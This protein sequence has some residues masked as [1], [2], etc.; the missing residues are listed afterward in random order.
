L[1]ASGMQDESM[2][3]EHYGTLPGREP[4][5]VTVQDA[6][7]ETGLSTQTIYDLAN[8]GEI[9][10]RYFGRKR[11]VVYASLRAYVESLPVEP[12]AA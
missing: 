3:T 5:T 12:T 1:H 8:K 11:L 10:T 9:E 6:A 2:P 4:L 7:R